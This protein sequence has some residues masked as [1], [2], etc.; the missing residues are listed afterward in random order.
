MNSRLVEVCENHRG[1]NVLGKVWGEIREIYSEEINRNHAERCICCNVKRSDVSYRK[2]LEETVCS[3]CLSL[4][5]K[6]FI[7]VECSY[8]HFIKSVL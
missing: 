4:V 2:E 1:S 6:L 5:N 7:Q 8:Y 3:V